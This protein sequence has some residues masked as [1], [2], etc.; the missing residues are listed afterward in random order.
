MPTFKKQVT[1][2]TMP[3]SF[4]EA[5]NK[6]QE[7]ANSLVDRQH[8]PTTELTKIGEQYVLPGAEKTPVKKGQTTLW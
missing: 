8:K 5:L 1:P 7:V 2:D 6:A 3:P 4:A